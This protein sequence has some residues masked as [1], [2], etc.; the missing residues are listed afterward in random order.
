MEV[1][2]EVLALALVLVLDHKPT[3]GRRISL[4][5]F[6]FGTCCCSTPFHTNFLTKYSRVGSRFVAFRLVARAFYSTCAALRSPVNL[7]TSPSLTT[8]VL[9]NQSN[10][11]NDLLQP[12]TI[13]NRC[14]SFTRFYSERKAACKPSCIAASN[15]SL[16]QTKTKRYLQPVRAAA[17]SPTPDCDR[18]TSCVALLRCTPLPTTEPL[19]IPYLPHSRHDHVLRLRF[20]L[21]LICDCA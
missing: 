18:P 6:S 21:R 4:L 11:S 2:V 7:C 14:A 15:P 20:T 16:R 12:R 8:A 19:P 3:R 1:E 5:C 10:I 17:A 9:V 13:Q